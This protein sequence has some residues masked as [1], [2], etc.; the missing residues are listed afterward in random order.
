MIG[1]GLAGLAAARTLVEHGVEVEIFEATDRI[2]GRAHTIEVEHRD[3][4]IELGPEFVHGAPDVTMNLVREASAEIDHLGNQNHV[5]QDGHLV[6]ERS[7]WR[8][9]GKLQIGRAHV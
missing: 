3:L 7:M 4:P 9:L 8:K 1:A 5:W 2:G 6:L